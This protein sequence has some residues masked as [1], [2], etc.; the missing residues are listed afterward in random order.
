MF[1]VIVCVVT[2]MNSYVGVVRVIAVFNSY[3]SMYVCADVHGVGHDAW[4]CWVV[5]VA[6]VGNCRNIVLLCWWCGRIRCC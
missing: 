2:V 3:V 6:F 4:S 1:C 5:F